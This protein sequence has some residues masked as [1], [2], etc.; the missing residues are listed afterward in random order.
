MCT[1]NNVVVECARPVVPKF[2]T[3]NSKYT[4]VLCVIDAKVIIRV[5]ETVTK[6]ENSDYYSNLLSSGNAHQNSFCEW[7]C[8]ETTAH[9][10]AI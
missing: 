1:K 5:L 8:I 10:G 2:P 4:W 9:S 6:N 7:L 3:K